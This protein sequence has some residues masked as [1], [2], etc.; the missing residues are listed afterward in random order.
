MDHVL[1][2]RINNIVFNYTQIG[3]EIFV[4]FAKLHQK[5]CELLFHM[6]GLSVF[7]VYFHDIKYSLHRK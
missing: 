7:F 3:S 2:Y 6:I 4:N 5:K 1:N